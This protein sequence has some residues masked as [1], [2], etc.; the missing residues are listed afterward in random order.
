MTIDG[1]C[2]PLA[3]Q[4]HHATARGWRLSDLKQKF[5]FQFTGAPRRQGDFAQVPRILSKFLG[6]N[7]RVAKLT[8]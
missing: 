1:I 2:L 6:S 3:H 5:P 7:A 4:R 8:A